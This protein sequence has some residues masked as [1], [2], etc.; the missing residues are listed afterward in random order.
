MKKSKATKILEKTAISEG[1][2]VAEI[3]RGIQ[4]AIDIAYEN[5]GETMP[6]FWGKWKNR[7]PTIEEFIVATN[8]SV[9]AKLKFGS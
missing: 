9:L 7:K 8:K 1:V 5:R 2:T 3:R 6:E 4:E